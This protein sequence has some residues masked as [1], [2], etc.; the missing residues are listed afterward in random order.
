MRMVMRHDELEDLVALVSQSFL[1]LTVN[2]ARCH[3]HKFD[4]IRQTDYYRLAAAL[5]GVKRGNRDLPIQ[6]PAELVAHYAA[7]EQELK[8]AAGTPGEEAAK[9]EVARLGAELAASRQTY[10]VTPQAAPV[11]HLLVRGDV[12][13]PSE[14]VA[15]GGVACLA[16]SGPDFGLDADASDQLRRVKLAE[17]IA[18]DENPLF[19]RT[20]VNRL[21]QHHFGRGLVETP[22]DLGFSGGRASHPELLDFLARELIAKG[23]SL[24]AIHRLIIT[25]DAYRQASL[26]RDECLAIDADNRLLWRCS[27]RRL[28][29][30]AVRDAMLAVSGQL[31]GQMRGPSFMDFRPYIHKTVQYYE[32]L[33]PPGGQFQRRSIYR[34]GARGGKHPLLD[35]FDCPDPSTAT[36]KRS[37]TTTPLQALALLNNSFTFRMA[38]ALAERLQSERPDSLGDQLSRAFDLAYGRHAT[39]DEL[40]AAAAFAEQHGLEAFCRVLLNTNGFLYVN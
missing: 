2:C 35:S 1:G 7:A 37:A 34:F 27:P 26:P 11:M 24:K 5:A 30:E 32:P 33:D 38:D 25:S 20:I 22:S 9:A 13:Q 31:N 17:W 19:A 23:W 6:P 21:W 4:P 12:T 3:D 16:D 28:E 18:S 14:V 39:T 36:P 29:A 40:Y 10:A 15:A 8:A